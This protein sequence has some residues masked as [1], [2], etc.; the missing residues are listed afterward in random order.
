MEQMLFILP[1]VA[2]VVWYALFYQIPFSRFPDSS[3]AF[4]II[5]TLDETRSKEI[6]MRGSISRL[7]Y[8]MIK[9]SHDRKVMHDLG[10]KSFDQS[11]G[12]DIEPSVSGTRLDIR[13]KR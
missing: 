2:A 10:I 6:L 7:E 8:W 13:R 1:I 4:E 5:Q 9:R 12:M 11:I 3:T